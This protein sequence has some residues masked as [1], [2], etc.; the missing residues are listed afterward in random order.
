MISLIVPIRRLK[1]SEV[2]HQRSLRE[3][4]TLS[5]PGAPSATVLLMKRR[6]S[7]P[8]S[9]TQEPRESKH[10][11]PTTQSFAIEVLE[12]QNHGFFSLY[13]KENGEDL[14]VGLFLVV[15]CGRKMFTASGR[16]II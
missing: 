16:N 8:L 4:P 15:L 11:S 12:W 14:L 3:H 13:E 7:G 2:C 9:G 1:H 10:A 5:S 6:H